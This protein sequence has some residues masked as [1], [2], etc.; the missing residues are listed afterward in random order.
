[1]PVN[2]PGRSRALRRPA[3]TVAALALST[4]GLLAAATPVHATDKK[5]TTLT[6]AP[7]RITK[8]VGQGVT[9]TFTLTSGSSRVPGKTVE[10]YTRPPSTT[11][12]THA[13]TRTLNSSGQTS[14]AFAVKRSTY[15]VA[16]FLGDA[17]YSGDLSGGALV[18]ATA[19]LGTRAVTEASKH[20]GQPYVYGAV[21]PDRFDCSGF[22]KY[23]F[24]R[25]GKTLPHNSGQQYGVVRH[26][27]KSSK[28]VGDLIFM[29][30]GGGIYHVA[31]YAGNGYIWHSPHSGD[32]VRK[33]AIWTSSYYVGRVA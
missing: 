18:T 28:Q 26:I 29:Y 2:H 15:V 12:W 23:V 3:A 4:A 1:M 6:V 24:S 13:W 7:Y 27:A 32:H 11:T 22:T 8:Q 21:G 20:Q 5:A 30:S 17:T 16:K 31:I 19:P 10:V 25:F 33:A 14:V 9:F